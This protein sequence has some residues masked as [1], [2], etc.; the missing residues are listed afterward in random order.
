MATNWFLAIDGDDIGR[1][2]EVYVITE[3]KNKLRELSQEFENLINE[4]FNQIKKNP[5]IKVLLHG[6]DSILLEMPRSEIETTVNLIRTTSRGTSFT[7]SG[8]YGKTMRDAYLALKLAKATGK[9]KIIPFTPE[10]LR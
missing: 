7:F 5:S 10:T 3:N 6:G 8:G 4:L 2:L 1:H 9:N